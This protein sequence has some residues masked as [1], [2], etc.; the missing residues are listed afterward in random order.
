MHSPL[1]HPRLAFHSLL[2]AVPLCVCAACAWSTIAT[3]DVIVE[4][5][6]TY[7]RVGD[8]ELKLDVAHPD[9]GSGPF[10]GIVFVHGGAWAGGE[11]T[12]YRGLIERAARNGYVAAQISYRLTGYAPATKSGGKVPFPAQLEDCKCAVRWMRSVADKYHVDPNRIGITGGSAGGHLSLMVGL[13][14]ED[15]GLEGTGGHAEYS[16]RVQCVVNYCGPTDLVHEYEHVEVVQPFLAAL[17]GG[18]PETASE[19][20]R[21]ASPINYLSPDDPP[22]LT[23]HG[24]QDDL[25]PVAQARMLDEK[26]KAAGLQHE[27]LVLKGQG[28]AIKSAQADAAFWR[29]L[30]THLKG[31]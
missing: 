18:T 1:R 7:G 15:A 4:E 9:N 17:C 11:R 26:L 8:L 16:S 22:I 14:G 3:A 23:L 28:H 19:A 10:P 21:I 6:V 24:D 20:Y 31:K 12:V 30:D 5:D 27:L 2:I 13:V 25:V 29:F